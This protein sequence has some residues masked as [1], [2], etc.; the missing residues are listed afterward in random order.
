MAPSPGIEGGFTHQPVNACF[1]AHPTKGVIAA[2]R[3]GG[4]FDARDFPGGQFDELR[5]KT[6]PFGPAQIHAQEHLGPVLGL[7]APGARLNVH[8][9]IGPV[10][11]PEEHPA[12]FELFQGAG[13][14]GK[15][16][17][18]LLKR[19]RIA[20]LQGQ[21]EELF[22]IG[23][24]L[25]QGHEHAHHGFEAGTLFPRAWAFSGD[26]QTPGSASSRSTSSNRSCWLATSK[27]PPERFAALAKIRQPF[28][29]SVAV[30]HGDLLRRRRF[31]RAGAA[32]N[33]ALPAEPQG[34]QWRGRWPPP[35]RCA[36]IGQWARRSRRLPPRCPGLSA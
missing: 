29:H 31:R 32:P 16:Y 5:T 2:K 10:H 34:R 24:P 12:K 7:R 9:T 21:D 35:L 19:L 11:G 36:S 22:R 27:I 8:V 3:K 26:S 25:A 13:L 23:K 33:R 18:Y 6:A 4:P 20:F 1:R 17:A 15:L 14:L 30:F 28:A